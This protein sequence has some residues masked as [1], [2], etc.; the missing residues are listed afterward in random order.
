MEQ[1]PFDADCLAVTIKASLRSAD[2]MD[3]DG[4]ICIERAFDEI[5]LVEIWAKQQWFGFNRYLLDLAMQARKDVGIAFGKPDPDLF[6]LQYHTLMDKPAFDF[7]G[8]FDP[9]VANNGGSGFSV[10]QFID[11]K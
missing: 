5:Y 8:T 10:K 7:T 3:F 6:P 4:T 2:G 11:R 1:N 9:F